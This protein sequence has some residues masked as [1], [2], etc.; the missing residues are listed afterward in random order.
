MKHTTYYIVNILIVY[1][2]YNI[3]S[4]IYYCDP[5]MSDTQSPLTWSSANLS[6]ATVGSAPGDKTKMSG[7]IHV[8]SLNDPFRSNG[9]GS[10]Y[11]LPIFSITNSCIAG[12][13]LSGRK[14]RR[15]NILW[16]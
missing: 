8:L 4:K 3:Y 7:D 1:K 2:A 11:R 10:T 12:I 9:G 13:I 15:T 6:R 14:Q 5:T 16:N